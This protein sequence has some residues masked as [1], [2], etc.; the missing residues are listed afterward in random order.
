MILDPSDIVT[1]HSQTLGLQ[2]VV[3]Q[4]LA[5]N[6]LTSAGGSA[7]PAGAVQGSLATSMATER[8]LGGAPMQ[9]GQSCR[10]QSNQTGEHRVHLLPGQLLHASLKMCASLRTTCPVGQ[11]QLGLNRHLLSSCSTLHQASPLA[12]ASSY[13]RRCASAASA[14]AGNLVAA[15]LRPEARA[16][17]A[18]DRDSFARHDG[19]QPQADQQGRIPIVK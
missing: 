9:V 5:R 13:S 18:I 4:L 14:Q 17:T 1:C 10:I 8:L 2:M 15:T 11:V 19:D 12:C 16:Q 7:G 3:Q 6:T